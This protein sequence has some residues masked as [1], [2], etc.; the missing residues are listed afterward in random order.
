M[1]NYLLEHI[2]LFIL[3]VFLLTRI[4]CCK[5]HE[6]TSKRIIRMSDGSGLL[7]ID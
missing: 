3:K 7:V 2:E 6:S 1:A 5:L 4:N